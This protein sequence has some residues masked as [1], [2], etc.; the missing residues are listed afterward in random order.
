ML[1]KFLFI[2]LIVQFSFCSLMAIDKYES[3][4]PPIV[5][6]EMKTY[7]LIEEEFSSSSEEDF[8]ESNPKLAPKKQQHTESTQDKCENVQ[9]MFAVTP[10]MCWPCLIPYVI[11]YSC[12][13]YFTDE[14]GRGE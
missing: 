1:K 12:M 13:I 7:F 5:T 4:V 10:V 2:I 3:E 14:E 6:K 11:A 8:L 9:T